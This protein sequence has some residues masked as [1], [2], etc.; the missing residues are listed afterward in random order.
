M[1]DSSNR[2]NHPSRAPSRS[3]MLGY[4]PPFAVVAHF[5]INDWP[6]S[7]AE[8]DRG[9]FGLV[10]CHGASSLTD[11]F[12][13]DFGIEVTHGSIDQSSSIGSS[14]QY[15]GSVSTSGRYPAILRSWQSSH[16]YVRKMPRAS[17]CGDHNLPEPQ[18]HGF[19]RHSFGMRII[20]S[21]VLEP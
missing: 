20:F 18:E 13:Q 8:A 3:W 6:A 16:V 1:R 14:V 11:G 17:Y 2:V 15:D 9:L 12:L 10:S 7:S 19:G 21:S 4:S 5:N